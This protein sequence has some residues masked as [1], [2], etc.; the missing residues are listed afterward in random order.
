MTMEHS[1][2]ERHSA[3]GEGDSRTPPEIN[4]EPRNLS[5][6]V[7]AELSTLWHG[8][9]AFKTAFFN[10]LSLQFPEGEHLFIK[11]VRDYRKNVKDPQLQQHIRGFIGQ[12]GM[13]S[14][15]HARY[16]DALAQRGYNLDKMNARFHKHMEFV[17]GFKRSR[18]L[19]GTCAAEHYTAV[20]AHGVLKNPDW[21]AGASPTMQALWRWHAVEEIEHKSVAFDVYQSQV[22]LYRMR[23]VAFWIVT[24]QFFRFTFLNTC[25]MLKTE[26]KFWDLK[27]WLHGLNFLWGKPGVLRQSLPQFLRYLRRDFHPWEVDDREEVARWLNNNERPTEAA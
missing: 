1:T 12:E 26:G 9:D 23:F 3:A 8:G 4:V 19:A 20:L 17:G 6:D 11:A 2:T 15:E 25:S 16:N 21:M 22:G 14:R 10:A 18:R 5:F 7:D 13:H 24:F 27:T